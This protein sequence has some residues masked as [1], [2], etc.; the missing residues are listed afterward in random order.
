MA[1]QRDTMASLRKKIVSLE[2]TID[3]MQRTIN[4]NYSA[5]TFLREEKTTLVKTI[6]KLT[7]VDL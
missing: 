5:I 2:T 4:T 1:R 7:D 3:S 6:A